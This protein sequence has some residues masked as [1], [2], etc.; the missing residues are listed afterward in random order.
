[1]FDGFTKALYGFAE[2]ITNFFVK[3]NE[4]EAIAEQKDKVKSRKAEVVKEL[5]RQKEKLTRKSQAPD[6]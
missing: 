1:M 2:A 5:Q 4:Q 3:V 6:E